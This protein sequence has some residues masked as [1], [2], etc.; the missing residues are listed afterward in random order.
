MPVGDKIRTVEYNTVQ[1]RVASVLGTG[2]GSLGY[3][4]TVQSSQVTTSNNI[5]INEWG[6]LR[7]DIINIYRH[8]TN[9]IPDTSVL[10][11]ATEGNS[12]RYNVTDAPV[13][14]W[15]TLSTTLLNNRINALPVGRFGTES[16][17]SRGTGV[18]FSN[19]ATGIVTFTWANSEN[20]RFFFNGGGR[21]RVQ[22]VYTPTLINSQ[23]TSWQTTLS[24]IGV[25]EWGG[26]FPDTSDSG[27]DG[28][29]FHKSD[30]TYRQF[31]TASSSSPYGSNTYNLDAAKFVDGSNYSVGIRARLVEGYTDLPAGD[32]DNPPPSDLVQGTLV[33]IASYTYPAGALTGL[34]A[35][36]WTEYQ[37]ASVVIGSFSTT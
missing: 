8:Q 2:S 9:T 22:T 12:I 26:F 25:R 3:G 27:T 4:Q 23:N 21:L 28:R 33:L 13:T 1:S 24:T 36:V 6:Q 32:P 31:Y 7:N 20:A 10:P 30:G 18:S 35:A 29:N 34:G 11:E 17:G 14:V 19:S 15:D 5:T 37:P 16:A